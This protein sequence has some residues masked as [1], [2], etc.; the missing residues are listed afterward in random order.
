[1]IKPW[2][3]P[4]LFGTGLVAGFVDSIAGGGGLI[5]MPVLL[6]FGLDPR[7]ALG[8]NKLQAVFGS[9]SATWHYARAGTVPL[10]DCKRGFA[11]TFIAAAAG[12][13]LVQQLPRDFLARMIPVLLL[14][15]AIYSLLRPNLGQTDTAPR[16]SRAGFDVVFGLSIGFYDGFFGPG[17]GT[18]WAMAFVLALGFNFTKATGY[19]KVMNFASNLSSLLVFLAAGQVLF[20]PGVTMGLG[21]LLGARIGSRTVVRHGARFIRPIFIGVVLALTLKLLYDVYFKQMFGSAATG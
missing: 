9:G 6:S 19:T 8:T 4:L 21:Q 20:L 16:L 15:I 2:H 14:A 1:M 5:T 18:F 7:A 11:I 13:L 17:T 10:S 12:T 3:L